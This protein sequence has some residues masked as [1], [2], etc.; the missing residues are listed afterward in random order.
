MRV[1]WLTDLHLNFVEQP[2]VDAFL[3]V[4]QASPADSF[5]ISG[6]IAEASDVCQYLVRLDEA[7]QRPIYFVLGNHDF[8]YG[9]IASVRAAVTDLCAGRPKLH[10]LSD[11]GV[12]ELAPNTGLI[13]HD[14]WADGR[15][16]NYERSFVMMNDYRLIKELAGVDKQTRWPLLQAMGD[17]AA[18]HIRRVLPEALERFPHVFLVTHVPPLREACWYDGRISDDEWAPHFTCKAVGDVILSIMPKYPDRQLVVLC[19]HTHSEGQAQPLPNVWIYT[20]GA[21][22]GHPAI[23]RTFELASTA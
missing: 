9:S 11:A 16:G 23:V 4:L 22:Y 13:G 18:D 15:I 2:A 14:G 8:Y 20:G 3:R 7:L 1:L 21:I 19:G 6:D 17:A 10:Y 5:L 12:L